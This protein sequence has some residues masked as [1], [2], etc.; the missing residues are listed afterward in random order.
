VAVEEVDL[1][2]QHVGEPG[3]AFVNVVVAADAAE[4]F[5]PRCLAGNFERGR[6][7]RDGV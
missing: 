7:G 2:A 5:G 6:D 4:Q 1:R 3:S